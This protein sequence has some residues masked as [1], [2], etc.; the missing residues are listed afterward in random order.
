MHTLSDPSNL[1]WTFSCLPDHA[2]CHSQHKSLS[3][4]SAVHSM[5]H[6]PMPPHNYLWHSALPHW[7]AA[8]HVLCYL[9][10]TSSLGLTYTWG[11]ANPNCL[12]A[13]ADADWATCPKTGCYVSAFV[14]LLNGACVAWRSKKQVAVDT[15]TSEA[16]FVSASSPADKLIW[17]CSILADLNL[18]QSSPTPLY[19][20]NRACR[21]MSEFEDSENPFH[22]EHSKHIDFC[23]HALRERV[24]AG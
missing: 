21:L 15:L 10:G 13:Y 12:I 22:C 16:E 18:H 7:H 2:S 4:E 24:T 23:V 1:V 14:V 3:A 19:E 9:K 20:D 17:E 11:C 6:S 5:W 8:K